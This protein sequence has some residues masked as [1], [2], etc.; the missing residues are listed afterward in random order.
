M[1]P[2]GSE[3]AQD[4]LLLLQEVMSL[5]A[6][7][8]YIHDLEGQY[9]FANR[10]TEARFGAPP[11]SFVGRTREE[12]FPPGDPAIVEYRRNDLEVIRRRTAITF[13]ETS[14]EAD[15][16]HTYLSV[17]YPLFGAA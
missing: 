10:S 16:T 4:L 7:S 15:G 9:L 3:R 2:A 12:V 11:G 1:N 14:E 5:S 17:K 6:P 13:E 8:I